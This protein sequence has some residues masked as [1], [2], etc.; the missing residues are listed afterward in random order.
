[1]RVVSF[2]PA[3]RRDLAEITLHIAEAAG[4]TIAAEVVLRIRSKCRLLADTPGEI[5]RAR[6]E[7]REGIRSFP[8]PPHLIFFRYG[9]DEVQIVRILHERQDFEGVLSE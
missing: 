9:D 3:A 6:P 2:S 5:G 7:I 8:V 1:M 4:P